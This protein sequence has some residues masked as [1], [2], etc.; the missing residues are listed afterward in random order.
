MRIR[1]RKT[2]RWKTAEKMKGEIIVKYELEVEKNRRGR[3]VFR[4]TKRRE[5][6]LRKI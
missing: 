3:K 2:K 5:R 4:G 1:R 6:K